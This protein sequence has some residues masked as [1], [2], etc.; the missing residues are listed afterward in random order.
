[1]CFY[2]FK[3]ELICRISAETKDLAGKVLRRWK[4][5][6]GSSQPA[7][8]KGNRPADMCVNALHRRVQNVLMVWFMG[9]RP[10]HRLKTVAR[11]RAI[12]AF[13]VCHWLL[14]RSGGRL[15]V[16]A[17]LLLFRPAASGPSKARVMEVVT[18][19]RSEL[20]AVKNLVKRCAVCSS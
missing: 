11:M 5:L 15:T 6:V 14:W 7:P 16:A 20:A 17:P 9:V 4:S 2:Y 1:V 18:L 3:K 10:A 19:D 13:R 8:E 12:R